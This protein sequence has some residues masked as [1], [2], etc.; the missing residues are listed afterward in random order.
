MKQPKVSFVVDG[1]LEFENEL[2]YP[3]MSSSIESQWLF[4]L[5]FKGLL[6]SI[7]LYNDEISLSLLT[8][9]YN[10]GPHMFSLI[11]GVVGTPQASFDTGHIILGQ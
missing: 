4:G 11:H 6:T 3:F 10:K 5:R 7:S 9:L 2:P 1:N 8:L